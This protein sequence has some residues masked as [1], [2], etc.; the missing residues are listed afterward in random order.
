VHLPSERI[1]P[2]SRGISEADT[3]GLIP[4]GPEKETPRNYY[5]PESRHIVY[6]YL[7]ESIDT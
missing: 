3:R 2:A 4:Q 6:Q 5:I 7:L 1:I